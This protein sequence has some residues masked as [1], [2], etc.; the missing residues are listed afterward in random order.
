MYRNAQLP[1]SLNLPS[2]MKYGTTVQAP[3]ADLEVG[4][5]REDLSSDGQAGVVSKHQ[6]DSFERKDSFA[7]RYRHLADPRAIALG[8]LAVA[9]YPEDAI[10]RLPDRYFG[11]AKFFTG[12][13]L[14]PFHVTRRG[15]MQYLLHLQLWD[16]DFRGKQVLDIGAGHSRFAQLTNLCF[17]DTGTNSFA[18]DFSTKPP[19]DTDMYANAFDLPFANNTFDLVVSS[20]MVQYYLDSR[21]FSSLMEELIRVCKPG[22]QIRFSIGLGQD[23]NGYITDELLDHPAVDRITRYPGLPMTGSRHIHLSDPLPSKT[24]MTA[25]YESLRNQGRLIVPWR[26]DLLDAEYR[27]KMDALMQGGIDEH[28]EFVRMLGPIVQSDNEVLARNPA[29]HFRTEKKAPEILFT[30]LADKSCDVDL[31]KEIMSLLLLH[32]SDKGDFKNAWSLLTDEEKDK[33]LSYWQSSDSYRQ[34]VLTRNPSIFPDT[35]ESL[36]LESSELIKN[37]TYAQHTHDLLLKRRI[38]KMGLLT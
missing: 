9:T 21:D 16:Y 11:L 35:P 20:W 33:V 15:V 4:N 26:R 23:H 25:Y 37:L 36:S 10:M 27:G 38:D 3:S 34:F 13:S 22:A 17:R 19:G 12:Q 18:I 8:T 29:E 28:I 6:V 7:A 5:D 30:W 32:F 1:T 2:W 24:E 31:K 14:W